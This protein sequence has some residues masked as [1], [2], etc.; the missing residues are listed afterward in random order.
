MPG[1]TGGTGDNDR[2]LR[3]PASLSTFLSKFF[4][5]ESKAGTQITD[6]L[7]AISALNPSFVEP[8]SSEISKADTGA[9]PAPFVHFDLVAKDW[10]IDLGAP[11]SKGSQYQW[12]LSLRTLRSSSAEGPSVTEYA[13][14]CQ[15]QCRH[16]HF[17]LSQLQVG[18]DPMP[19][20]AP[21]WDLRASMLS[22]EA[23]RAFLKDILATES[24][25]DYLAYHIGA[26]CYDSVKRAKS[27]IIPHARLVFPSDRKGT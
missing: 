17:E 7:R 2:A 8:A 21:L 22:K 1:S 9:V 18:Y 6:N 25:S 4:P 19:Q 14:T 13:G 24:Y 12:D 27:G 20:A 16:S 10:V 3:W 15:I 23:F 5:G 26:L 11:A